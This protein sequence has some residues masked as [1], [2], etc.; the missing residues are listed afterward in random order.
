[1]S[2]FQKVMSA[3]VDHSD[4]SLGDGWL[5]EHA[6]G[7]APERWNQGVCP[8][9]RGRVAADAIVKAIRNARRTVMVSS[10]LLADVEI[11]RALLEVATSGRG[12]RVYVLNAAEARLEK[13]PR[14]DSEFDRKT[15]E[16]H[17]A[18]LNKLA[19]YVLFRTARSFHA[20]VVLVD[21]PTGEGYLLTANLT[22]EALERNEEVVIRLE[23]SECAQVRDWLQYAFWEGA[24]HEMATPG[25]LE[26][27]RAPGL[28]RRPE[29]RGDVLATAS[30]HTGLREALLSLVDGARG[31]LIVTSF[32]WS[33]EHPVVQ[34]IL[35][36][37]RQG[38][39]VTVLAR[40]RPSA[41]PALLA[42]REAGATVLGFQWLHAKAA[43]SEAGEALVT[44]ANLEPHGMDD[45][46]ELGVRLVGARAD[47]V[48]SLLKAWSAGAK[49]RLENGLRVGAVH[50]AVELWRGGKV[51][52]KVVVEASREIDLGRVVA[53]SATRLEAPAPTPPAPVP[54]KYFH[55]SILRW[56]IDA[57]VLDTKASEVLREVEVTGEAK[58]G[59]KT[60]K[61]KQRVSHEPPLFKEASGRLVVAISN[62]EQLEAALAYGREH[63]ATVVVRRP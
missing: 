35:Q 55:R 32:G 47:A 2:P 10:F 58:A 44:S 11:E 36:R 22:S 49:A 28:T 21:A 40:I 63:G 50:G 43:W 6:P 29:P 33:R 17:K 25:A 42:L 9:G 61:K 14:E 16:A 24:E 51:L 53:E 60:K 31:H 48:A 1:M 52:E 57:P 45:G 19:G 39:R 37:A 41:M 12:V 46:F 20:K 30:G 59:E 18:L 38:L 5:P 4:E 13:E 23:E 34:R 27:V 8:S 15:Y 26:A 3:E 7:A 62:A 56:T 54:G